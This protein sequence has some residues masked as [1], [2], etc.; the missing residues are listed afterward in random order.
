MQDINNM[1]LRDFF[2]LQDYLLRRDQ[3]QKGQPVALRDSNK[4]MIN[5]FKEKQKQEQKKDDRNRDES[6]VIHSKKT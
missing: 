3:K 5:R 1:F 2:T 4:E 6:P